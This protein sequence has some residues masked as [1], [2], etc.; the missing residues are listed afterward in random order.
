MEQLQ[1]EVSSLRVEREEL[2][3]RVQQ[4]TVQHRTSSDELHTLQQVSAA[5]VTGDTLT[6]DSCESAL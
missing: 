5:A 2:S 6:G 3:I 1:S 4:L